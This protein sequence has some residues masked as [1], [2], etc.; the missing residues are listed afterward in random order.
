MRTGGR[1]ASCNSDRDMS[2]R[3]PHPLVLALLS[4]LAVGIPAEAGAAA[5]TATRHVVM[6][7][8]DGLRPDFVSPQYTPTLH[9]LA[10][11]GTFFRRHH[12]SYVSSTEVNGTA[13]A[14]GAHP[15]HSGILANSQYRPDLSWLGPFGTEQLDPVRRG[16]L[17]SGGRYLAVP[18]LPE[19]LQAAGIPTAVAGSK[20][21]VLLHDR[22]PRGTNAAQR[23]SVNLFRGVTLP[24]AALEVLKTN[25]AIGPPPTPAIDPASNKERLLSWVR[26][27]RD[28][29]L[30][31]LGGNPV[32]TP[33]S[34]RWDTWTTRALVHGLWEPSVP[35]YSVLWLAEPDASQHETSPGSPHALA[36]LRT[37][38]QHL[39][40][41]IQA[42]KDR[43][44]FE[45]T[46]ILVVSD[47]GFSTVDHGPDLTAALRGAGFVAGT[48]FSNPEAG[49]VLTVNLGGSTLFYV[50]DHHPPTVERLVEFLQ[51]TDFAGVIFSAVPLPGTFPLSLARVDTGPTAPDVVVAMR[52]KEARNAW[53][54]PGTIAA[55]GGRIGSGAHG[56]LSRFDMNNTLIAAGPGF[57]AGLVN[58]TPSGNIDLAPTVLALLGVPA[59]DSVDGRVLTEALANVPA[60]S[61]P[62]KAQ[63]ETFKASHDLGYR[64]W[65]Q[66]LT[67][68]RVGGVIYLDEGNGEATLK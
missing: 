61:A 52:W 58:E 1:R 27:A 35:K 9:E 31:Q 30:T 44:A 11:R 17:L 16:D 23:E 39:A 25:S 64:Q 26:K 45:Q 32:V 48:S 63:S 20:G 21:V 43:G 47:H 6:V 18:T 4:V 62:P 7:V 22:A 66:T 3:R 46:D 13:L 50:F 19:L 41:L 34:R 65:T 60:G 56:S 36:A 55:V 28:K 42:L 53:G 59:P 12:C 33:D 57:R 5:E 67:V 24:R 14:T 51:G 8:W 37:A 15:A 40:E 29:A 2:R 49:D 38:D 68:S 10:R 54:T